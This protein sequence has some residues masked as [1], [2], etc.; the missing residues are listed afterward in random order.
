MIDDRQ[1][2]SCPHQNVRYQNAIPYATNPTPY[3]GTQCLFVKETRNILTE[4]TKCPN[5]Y[6]GYAVLNN[7]VHF[8]ETHK[9][10]V[11]LAT[12][13]D[14]TYAGRFY[15]TAAVRKLHWVTCPKVEVI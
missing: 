15:Q 6:S 12:D 8:P 13:L 5:R 11:G 9:R 2:P 4:P 14:T 3:L 7:P 10:T 1:R